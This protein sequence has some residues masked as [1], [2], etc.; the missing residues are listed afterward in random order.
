MYKMHYITQSAQ[1]HQ[2]DMPR[3]SSAHTNATLKTE[4]NSRVKHH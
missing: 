4:H 3:T 1:L 2:C